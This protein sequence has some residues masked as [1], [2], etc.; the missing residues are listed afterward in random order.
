MSQR[1]TAFALV[2]SQHFSHLLSHLSLC[3]LILSAAM[4][5][6][7][8]QPITPTHPPL[9]PARLSPLASGTTGPLISS[10]IRHLHSSLAPRTHLLPLRRELAQGAFQSLHPVPHLGA[11]QH[12]INNPY[13][14]APSFAVHP[15]KTRPRSAPGQRLDSDTRSSRAPI[16]TPGIADSNGGLTSS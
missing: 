9:P 3:S 10:S 4:H 1:H 15:V 8:S 7:P 6:F 13:I 2:L 14:H 11:H 5:S 16:A 12:D